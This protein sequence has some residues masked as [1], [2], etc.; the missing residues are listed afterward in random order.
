MSYKKPEAPHS[1]T[2][3]EHGWQEQLYNNSQQNYH[4][5]KKEYEQIKERNILD[6]LSECSFVPSINQKSL[7]GKKNAKEEQIFKEKAEE[8]LRQQALHLK[9][10]QD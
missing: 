8:V 4:S 6:E 2:P 1:F 9:A 3:V 10:R 7:K 5:K